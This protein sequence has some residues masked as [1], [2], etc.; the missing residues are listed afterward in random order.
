MSH[1][2]SEPALSAD[3]PFNNLSIFSA[4]M[5]QADKETRVMQVVYARAPGLQRFPTLDDAMGDALI[6]KTLRAAARAITTH[7]RRRNRSPRPQRED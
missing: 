6:A 1:L 2:S 5:T 4:S 7:P 3:Y